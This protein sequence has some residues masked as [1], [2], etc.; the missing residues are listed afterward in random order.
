MVLAFAVR[1]LAPN[2][3]PVAGRPDIADVRSGVCAK[4]ERIRL[5]NRD[6]FI[7]VSTHGKDEI[8]YEAQV[9]AFVGDKERREDAEAYVASLIKVTEEDDAVTIDTEPGE[10]PDFVDL[11][12]FYRVW[13]PAGTNIEIVSDNGNV[14]VMR[15]CGSVEVSG[16]NA[17]IL[18][19]NPS[20]NVVVNTVNGRIRLKD[21]SEGGRLRTVNGSVYAEMNG[22]FLTAETTNG[23]IRARFKQDTV[24]GCDL[25]S[26]NGGIT[27]LLDDGCS[28]RLSARTKRGN[29]TTDFAVD[30]SQGTRGR[31]HLEGVIGE[32]RAALTLGT[33]NGD[34]AIA[35]SNS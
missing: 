8:R 17:D 31:R 9:K 28:A 30:T 29:V 22:G 10:R 15:G 23:V 4:M 2:L 24:D 1:V 32:G 7:M 35:R 21:A 19:E 20:G 34:I 11:L 25:T 12:V 26:R 13:V 27:V 3:P 14:L 33:L 18:V 6:G 16:Q 5:Q